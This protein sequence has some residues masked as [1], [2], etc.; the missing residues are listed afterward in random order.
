MQPRSPN[1]FPHK[2]GGH[3]RDRLPIV[4]ITR[5]KPKSQE[6]AMLIDNQMKLEAVEP[7]SRTPADGGF[8]SFSYLFE[9]LVGFYAQIVTDPDQAGVDK[10]NTGYFSFSGIQ[11]ST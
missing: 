5:G 7:E 2:D 6:V 10:R 11:V 1:S 8:A 3:L 9:N 4:N